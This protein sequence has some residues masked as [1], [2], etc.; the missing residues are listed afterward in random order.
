MFSAKAEEPTTSPIGA[1]VESGYGE[2]DVN[3]YDGIDPTDLVS[4]IALESK[5]GPRDEK[6][7]EE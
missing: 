6:P 5:M 2:G 3:H 4:N 7:L 1:K